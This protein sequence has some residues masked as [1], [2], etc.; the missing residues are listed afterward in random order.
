MDRLTVA[1]AEHDRISRLVFFDAGDEDAAFA[2]VDEHFARR[3]PPAAAAA[4]AAVVATIDSY[5]RSA[6]DEYEAMLSSAGDV[7]DHRT[8]GFGAVARPRW[9]DAAR[10]LETLM[11]GRRMRITGVH[12]FD[13][14]GGVFS[15]AV[16]GADA[17]GSTSEYRAQI[18]TTFDDVG[19]AT[20]FELFDEEAREAAVARLDTL[21]SR[22]W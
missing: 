19:V 4:W 3:L 17:K 20:A 14:G 15:V 5:N 1:T 7:V 13:A 16:R 6:W 8:L 12:R 2:E 18:L 10:S 9:V 11:P 21:R 22:A